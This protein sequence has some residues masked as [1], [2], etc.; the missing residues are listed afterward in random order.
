MDYVA[1]LLQQRKKIRQQQQQ[2]IFFFTLSSEKDFHMRFY[3]MEHF[4][5]FTP[6]TAIVVL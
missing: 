4:L 5:E 3:T 2:Q 1:L 6:L